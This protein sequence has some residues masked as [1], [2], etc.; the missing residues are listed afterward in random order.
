MTPESQIAFTQHWGAVEPHPLGSRADSHPADMPR[1][2]MVAQNTMKN[3]TVTSGKGTV[4]NDI[5]HSDLS[6][7][8]EPVGLSV[9]RAVELPPPGWGDTMFANMQ[10][11]LDT[12]PSSL[13]EQVDSL[14]AV[15][16]T[17]HFEGAG[18]KEAFKKSSSN[19]HPVV[20]THPKTRRNALYLSGNFIHN[21]EGMTHEKSRDLLKTLIDHATMP[22]NVYRHRWHPGDLVVWDNRAT[23]HY[24]V[25]D[26]RPG[27]PRV[28]HRTTSAGER[29]FRDL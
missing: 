2:V 21:F 8:S 24:A 26:Y 19:L 10:N 4:R 28:L 12:L 1:N 14:N 23:M 16:N 6:C 20:R 18:R 7:M 25:F 11:A 15:H 3:N 17:A 9:L 29:P 13:H 22:E 27:Q 5:W